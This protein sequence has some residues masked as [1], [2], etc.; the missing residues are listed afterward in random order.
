MNTA[1]DKRPVIPTRKLD[2]LFSALKNWAVIRNEDV[3]QNFLDGGDCDIICKDLV[4]CGEQIIAH[5]GVPLRIAARSYVVSYYYEWGHID[6]TDNIYWRGLTLAEGDQIL[7]RK[8]YLGN[9]P[10]V[11]D[12]DESIVSLLNSV[13]WGGFVKKRYVFK[14]HEIFSNTQSE[15]ER[16]LHHMLGKNASK[17]LIEKSMEHDWDAIEKNVRDLR[18]LTKCHH[19]T[20]H[21][22]RS[23]SGYVSFFFSEFR[24]RVSPGIPALILRN[25]ELFGNK[26]L[27]SFIL[28]SLEQNEFR[29]KVIQLKYS[30]SVL[31]KIELLKHRFLNSS[32]MARNGLLIF[33]THNSNFEIQSASFHV[34]DVKDLHFDKF[35]EDVCKVMRNFTK[36]PLVIQ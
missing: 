12:A 10:M 32:F 25:R 30:I 9:L 7:S 35:S 19:F 24:L 36:L 26:N 33:L 17:L 8:R 3:I 15:V 1:S 28:K 13:L 27:K 20:K 29:A 14:I 5:L 11:S 16:I 34:M 23:L 31:T 21:P 6:L 4:E 22:K 18:N 2:R